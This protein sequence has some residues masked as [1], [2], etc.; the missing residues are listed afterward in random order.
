MATSAGCDEIFS[1]HFTVNLPRNLSVKKIVNQ[2]RFDRIMA[3]SL[4]PHFLG[5]PCIWVAVGKIAQNV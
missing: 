4:W 5:P 3:T 1:Q 2:L